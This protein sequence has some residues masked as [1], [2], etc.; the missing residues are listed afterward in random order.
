M[1]KH[2]SH[3]AAIVVSTI[4]VV[5]SYRSHVVTWK[6]QL[7][8]AIRASNRLDVLVF[9]RIDRSCHSHV[10]WRYAPII[11]LLYAA[12]AIAICVYS[13]EPILCSNV[14]YYSISLR[15]RFARS[16]L[17]MFGFAHTDR[18]LVMFMYI[19]DMHLY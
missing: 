1:F 11:L 9:A 14:P 16:R 5:M 7:G 6:V 10:D 19:D 3:R 8:F 4:W 12:I 17:D 13:Y 15:R 18:N 2:V